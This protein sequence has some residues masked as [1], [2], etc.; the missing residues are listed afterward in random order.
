MGAFN[1]IPHLLKLPFCSE[2]A[3]KAVSSEEA[4]A[5]LG[6]SDYVYPWGDWVTL[7]CRHMQQ[8]LDASVPL[9]ERYGVCCC[10][11][12]TLLLLFREL[13]YV[14]CKQP[15]LDFCGK[16]LFPNMRPKERPG[17]AGRRK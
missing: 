6:T 5:L 16:E 11:V 1:F 8:T 13:G 14:S 17:N 15:F 9:N 3:S 10:A 12:L 2:Q 7:F 4:S